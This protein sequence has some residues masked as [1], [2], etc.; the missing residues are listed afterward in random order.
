ME[1]GYIIYERTI[2]KNKMKKAWLNFRINQ[3]LKDWR[4]H[5]D[6]LLDELYIHESLAISEN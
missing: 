6:F 5:L 2:Q 3:C 4:D 1:G